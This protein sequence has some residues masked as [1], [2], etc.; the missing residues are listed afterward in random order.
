MGSAVLPD[1]APVL[2]PHFPRDL[3]LFKATGVE[4]HEDRWRIPLTHHLD[5]QE[6]FSL[7]LRWDG[8]QR[9]K[10]FVVIGE[11]VHAPYAP[12]LEPR[13]RKISSDPAT[14]VGERECQLTFGTYQDE[15]FINV[16]VSTWLTLS[17]SLVQVF[18]ESGSLSD[19]RRD[20]FFSW[21][22]PFMDRLT[23]SGAMVYN[24]RD[25]LKSKEPSLY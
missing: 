15:H 14:R 18:R 20:H 24:L 8:E 7:W 11:V 22:D 6:R 17:D 5:G 9:I 13:L 3:F 10:L 25:E 19:K 4:P 1:L 23:I 21:M 16:Q 2:A 12:L